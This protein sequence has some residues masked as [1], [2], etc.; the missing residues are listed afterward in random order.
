MTNLTK[1][2]S[3]IH[4]SVSEASTVARNHS[5]SYLQDDYFEEEVDGT[6][7]KTGV[8]I[9]KMLQ[10]KLPVVR[11]GVMEHQ[12][13]SVPLYSLAKHQSLCMDEV[14]IT[15]NID[16]RDV[17]EDVVVSLTH[18]WFTEPTKAKVEMTFK[19]ADPPEGIMKIND[20]LVK[21]IP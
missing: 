10:I 1:L 8:L 20:R 17:K 19:G 4:N 21:T 6:G 5:L 13:V 3:A 12:E 16:L 7:K 11:G 15:L 18:K 9:P 14:K 2:F